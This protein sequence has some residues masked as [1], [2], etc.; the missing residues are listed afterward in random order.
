MSSKKKH[1]SDNKKSKKEKNR[2]DIRLIEIKY[3]VDNID[4]ILKNEKIIK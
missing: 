2:I 1:K 3:N 4:N